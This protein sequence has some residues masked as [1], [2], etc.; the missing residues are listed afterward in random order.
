MTENNR[1]HL[2]ALVRYLR[3]QNNRLNKSD[4]NPNAEYTRVATY[5]ESIRK[6]A[7]E[8]YYPTER[9]ELSVP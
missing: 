1:G 5:R 7:S 6:E 4:N 2:A 9:P 8:S 3:E